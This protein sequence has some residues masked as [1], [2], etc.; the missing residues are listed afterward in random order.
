M[1]RCAVIDLQ[2]NQ[3]VNTII[4]EVTD[5]APNGYKLVEILPGYYWNEFAGQ[6]VPKTQYWDGSQLQTIPDGYYWDGTQLQ[7]INYGN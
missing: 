1:A 7:V 4:A 2:T 3:R 6:S 5:L